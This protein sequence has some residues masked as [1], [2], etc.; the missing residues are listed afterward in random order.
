MGVSPFAKALGLA[1]HAEGGWYRETWR[2]S[3]TVETPR[4]PRSAGTS[5]V[6]LLEG[7]EFC[8]LHRLFF[9]EVWHWH[10][11][12]A[13]L[14]HML[15]P[16]GV[17]TGVLDAA[18]PQFVVPG[19]TWFAAEPAAGA[20]HVLAGCTLAPGYEAADFELAIRE[21]LLVEFP[22]AGELIVRFT[23]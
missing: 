8:R 19:G 22:E 20:S 11:G 18:R 4:G 16:E 10:G 6:Y 13:L 7:G 9:D 12:G 1:P 3:L 23:G 2:S 14:V 15:Q 21:E 5:I 17:A